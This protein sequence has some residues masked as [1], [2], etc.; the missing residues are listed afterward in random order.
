MSKK[1]YKYMNCAQPKWH[2]IDNIEAFDLKEVKSFHPADPR[3]IAYWKEEKRRCI[4]GLWR[5][6]FGKWM[7]MPGCLY[8][9][10]K[11]G[12][13]VDTDKFTKITEK[14]KP[15]IHDLEWEGAFDYWEA[16]GF[17]GWEGDDEFTSDEL[18]FQFKK[19]GIPT[20]EELNEMK[21]ELKE[22]FLN[23]IKSDGTLK[24]YIS[25]R[26]NLRKLQDLPRGRPLF[27]NDARNTIEIGS[28]GGGKSYREG[29]MKHLY[30]LCFDGATKYPSDKVQKIETCIGSGDTDKSGELVQKIVDAM[31]EFAINPKLGV[32]GQQ[33]DADWTPNPLYR[34][35]NG[36]TGPGNKQKGGWVHKYKKKVQGRWVDGFGTG[37]RM[38]H[39]SYSSNKKSGAEAGAG[40]RYNVTSIEETGITGN[41][42]EVWNSNEA[43][44]RRNGVPF[45]VQSL[46]GTSGNV[47]LILPSKE[48]FTN[49]EDYRMIS[50]DD[51]WEN[52]GKIGRF[53]PAYMTFRQFK[54]K[55]GNTD[56]K[57][58][59]AHWLKGYEQAVKSANPKTLRMYCMNY[60]DIPSHMWVTDTH[61]LLPYEE[62][63]ARIK[64]LM[65]K[66]WYKSIGKAITLRWDPT[67]QTGVNY[68]IK[69][70]PEPFYDFPIRK[71]RENIDGEIMIYQDPELVNGRIPSDM[72]L[73]THDPYV[74][75]AQDEGGSLGVTHVWLSP[76]YESTHNAYNLVATYIGKPKGGKKEYYENLE[77][78]L[79]FYG[80]PIRG[81]NYE[82]NRGEFCRSYF[83]RKKKGWLLMPRPQFSRGDATKMKPMVTQFGTLVGASGSISKMTMVDDTHDLL[84]EPV[85]H[86]GQ[87]KPLISTI[88]CIFT[89]RQTSQFTMDG[90][91]DAVSSMILFPTSCNELKH[92]LEE[93]IRKKNTNRLSF[94]STNRILR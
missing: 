89:L 58:A 75:D 91:F 66:N 85:P 25:P 34:D 23:V 67:Q 78:L 7:H 1:E 53:L 27:Q 47:E 69:H 76:K 84:L 3:Y 65:S 18:Y 77:K 56:V 11:F 44:V 2:R 73:F 68:E 5:K 71:D 51:V 22:V 41:V 42:I 14:I 64:E 52:T 92:Y 61:Y 62:S 94:L 6:Q 74:S 45:G 20:A 38:F 46:L 55:N 10:G 19:E 80:N 87:T 28:R 4:E 36:P 32:W 15:L 50:H 37:T 90:N 33:G 63:E 16:R 79:A 49:P 40:G 13:I 21:P 83:L 86:N 8:F 70:N 43:T 60:P 17:S 30:N 29:L 26:E 39:V 24:T 82:S 35:M 54:D 31:N 88:P 72:Y 9:Y 93:Q 12:I 57:A 59:R 48:I 81:L